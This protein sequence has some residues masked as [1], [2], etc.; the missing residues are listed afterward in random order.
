M[1]ALFCLK[2]MHNSCKTEWSYNKRCRAALSPKIMRAQTLA[3]AK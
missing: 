2:P 1:R 3:G